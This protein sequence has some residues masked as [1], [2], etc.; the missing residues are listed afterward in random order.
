M[1]L[2]GKLKIILKNAWQLLSVPLFYYRAVH[3]KCA[4]S[5]Y[6]QLKVDEILKQKT[7]LTSMRQRGRIYAYECNGFSPPLLSFASA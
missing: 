7:F 2:I 1:Y 3:D 6:R 5:S 4:Y